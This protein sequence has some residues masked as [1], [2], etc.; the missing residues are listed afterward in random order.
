MTAQQ[1]TTATHPPG[2][3]LYVFFIVSGSSTA[4]CL[5]YF[6]IALTIV[7]SRFFFKKEVTVACCICQF[8]KAR[9]TLSV[10]ILVGFFVK[11][12]ICQL[13]G[14]F[15]IENKMVVVIIT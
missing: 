3:Y 8:Q 6:M 13:G 4:I 7:K 14:M 15:E 10:I 9:L 5:S 1:H 11:I 12:I 2:R